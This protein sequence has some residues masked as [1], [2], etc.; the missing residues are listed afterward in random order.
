MGQNTREEG[1]AIKRVLEICRG[2]LMDV[3]LGID[4]RMT[5]KKKTTHTH[6]TNDQGRTTRTTGMET[7]E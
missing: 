3:W 1:V 4:L 5:G 7:A 6:T 2:L